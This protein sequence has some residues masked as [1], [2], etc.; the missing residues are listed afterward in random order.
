MNREQA[1]TRP[2]EATAE[3]QEVK[4]K[5]IGYPA[6]VSRRGEGGRVSYVGVPCVRVRGESDGQLS[7]QRECPWTWSTM[8]HPVCDACA[9]FVRVVELYGVLSCWVMLR[10]RTPLSEGKKRPTDRKRSLNLRPLKK[11]KASSKCDCRICAR[12]DLF[13]PLTLLRSPVL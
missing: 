5:E 11:E 6:A 4:E 1:A 12:E 3:T 9:A 10:S 13:K 8:R 7:L 2:Q